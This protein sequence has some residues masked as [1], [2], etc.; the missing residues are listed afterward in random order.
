MADVACDFTKVRIEQQSDERVRVS[1]ARGQPPTSTYKVTTTYV[2]GWRNDGL[3][4]I[5]GIDAHRKAQRTAEAIFERTSGMV[6]ARRASA[7]CV[8]FPCER[9][10]LTTRAH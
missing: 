6:S 2:D 9:S 5:S 8:G 10:P 3:I 4:V 1:H 7:P